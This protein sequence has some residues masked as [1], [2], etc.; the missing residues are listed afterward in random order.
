[1]RSYRRIVY[2]M[3]LVAACLTVCLS[4]TVRTYAQTMTD[5]CVYPPFVTRAVPPLVMLV[6]SKDDKLFY[7][8]YNDMVD[9][10]GDGT[11]DST[12]N[13][14]IDYYGYF[15]PNL[16]YTYSSSRFNPAGVASGAHNH[17]CSGQWSGNF[18]NWSTMTR[19]DIIRKVL[20]GG[21]RLTDSTSLTVLTRSLLPRDSHS[22]AKA[23]DGADISSLTPVNWAEGITMCNTNT[24]SGETSGLVFSVRGFYPFAAATEVKQCTKTCEGTG[25]VNLSDQGFNNLA[26]VNAV[27]KYAKFYTDI[28]VCDSSVGLESNCDAFGSNYKP[29]GL[30]Q[31][32]GI[33]KQSGQNFPLMYFGLI[34]G[35]YNGN[36]SGG[37]LRSKMTDIGTTE[38]D[39]DTGQIKTGSKIIKNIDRFQIVEYDYSSGSYTNCNPG[40]P[41]VLTDGICRSSGNPVGEMFYEVIRYFQGRATPTTQFKK[42]S[43]DAGLLSLTVESSWDNP[44]AT[45]PSCSR[46]FILALSDIYPNY[47]S[48]Q[49]P[50][51]YWYST[52][53]TSDTPSVQTLLNDSGI[54]TLETL[55]SIFIGDA[56]G[57][58]YDKQCTPKTA[59]NFGQIRG[60]CVEEPTKRGSYYIAGLANYARKTDINTVKGDQKISTYIV[61]T[62]GTAVPIDV[63]VGSNKVT[64]VPNFQDMSDSSKGRIVNMN[65]CPANDADWIAEQANGYTIC[66]DV[67]WDDAEYGTDYDLDIA[68]RHYVQASGG[69]VTI[70]SKGMYAAAGHRNWAG[71]TISGVTLPGTYYDIG[72]GG[73]IG[74]SNTKCRRVLDENPAHYNNSSGL[75]TYT[76]TD[77][78]ADKSRVRTFTSAGAT[79]GILHD[80]LW[81]AAKYGGLEDL[82][83]DSTP[84]QQSEWDKNNDGIPDTYYYA[85]NPLQLYTELGK[86]L[87]DI[88][89]RTSS[90]TAASVLA[91]AEGSGANILQAVFYPRRI[92]SDAELT[93]TG[94]LRNLWYY[95]DP[96]LQATTMRED[97]EANQVLHLVHDYIVQFY[98]DTVSNKTKVKRYNDTNA[99]GSPDALVDQIELENLSNIWEAGSVLWARNIGSSPRTILT[100]LNGV[101]FLSGDFSTANASTL[102]PYLNAS[103]DAEATAIIN[104]AHGIDQ[105]GYRSRTVTIGGTTNVWK[106]GDIITSTPRIQ[107]TN[108]INTYHLPPPDGYSDSTY[109]A[110]IK[111]SAY[112]SR[113]MAYSGANDGM[114]H[115]FKLGKLEQK[116]DGQGTNEIAR[117]TG[118]DLG[119]EMWAFIPKNSLPYLKYM[120]A[121]DYCHVYTIDNP[122][123]LVDAS[124]YSASGTNQNP[125]YAKNKESWRTILIGGMGLGGAC[126]NLG[127]SCTDCVKT[128]VTDLGYSSYFALDVTD[129]SSPQLLWEFSNPAL[130]F[131]T[132]GPAVLRIGD[133]ANNGKWFVVFASGPTGGINTLWNQ[134]MGKSDQNLK[135]FV[136]DMYNGSLLKTIDTGIAY[137]FGGSLYNSMLDVNRGD[138]FST[139]RYSDDVFYLGYTKKDT[140]TGT[141]TKGGVLRVYTNKDLLP[142]NWTTSS[143]VEDIGPVT[144]TISKLQD[145]TRQNLWLYFGTGRFYYKNNFGTD[146]DDADGQRT[147][148]G[149]KEPCYTTY[150]TMNTSCFTPVNQSNLTDQTS[151]PQASLPSGSSGWFINLDATDATYK[152]ER[153]ITDPLAIFSGVTFFT[154]FKPSSDPC[155]LGGNTQIWAVNYSTGGAASSSALNGK[156]I[157]QVSTGEIKELSLGSVFSQKD[158][159]RTT[160]MQGV[161]PRG[162]GLSVLIGPRPLKKILHIQEK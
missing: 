3:L 130:G 60:L 81:Y 31:K 157:F 83:G 49:L 118:S 73:G 131:S 86:A 5:Y 2:R 148:Y 85:S 24:G 153:V 145:R 129:P 114:L 115:A 53:S 88:L 56:V 127:D 106:L 25:C 102:R 89:D 125:T 108:P 149:V 51:S 42:T 124:V 90:G 1:M 155:E 12:Y 119:K 105:T 21:K 93:W 16:C 126:R 101:S 140:A 134:F 23:Y 142:D 63:T 22:F 11:I 48:D 159:R 137:A 10:D 46:P 68:I 94:E 14:A 17:Y 77:S 40:S 55:G 9:L 96:Y 38:V 107:S 91:S 92:Y 151:S 156:A 67:Q 32:Y 72:C 15:N 95:I 29:G 7:K 62:E 20:Y 28:K 52:I 110:Y 121:T 44:Y 141:W 123:Y 117:L 113:G 75:P 37:V 98:L 4:S 82:N 128:P 136:L 152:A 87:T 147:I 116:W 111:D 78:D 19:I 100:T 69:T 66:R 161:P 80:P 144:T 30:L 43:P 50:G 146:I 27:A 97:T 138:R 99:D 74:G 6:V 36:V 34:T 64:I 26:A 70:K 150:N 47:D 41:Y 112:L 132:S 76:G 84:D 103:T 71:Y 54:N 154:T 35:S 160:G 33:N 139:N 65:V 79:A 57:T 120:T 158:S 104:Y 59:S 133:A 13:D 18:L 122:S 143:V 58:T 162:Q 109:L 61:A 45:Y 39:I 135:L 8:G